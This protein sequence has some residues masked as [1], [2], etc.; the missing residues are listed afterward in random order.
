MQVC[1]FYAD[2]RALCLLTLVAR[3][4][5]A[6]LSLTHMFDLVVAPT[7]GSG[8]FSPVAPAAVHVLLLVAVCLGSAAC[9][10][11]EKPSSAA[12]SAPKNDI[13]FIKGF[14]DEE[15]SPNLT[16]RWMEN[17]GVIRLANT[18]R[19]MVLRLQGSALEHLD[20]TPTVTIELNGQLLDR[21]TGSMD[22]ETE[23]EVGAAMQSS[24]DASEL[25]IR[26][27]QVVVPSA[28]GISGDS[29]HLGLSMTEVSWQP[30]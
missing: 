2:F 23:Y 7:G 9:G 17:E 22:F 3:C 1:R 20:R 30:R 25:V 10:R 19:D 16:W 18:H 11:S 29:R 15:R 4:L 14:Y 5:L 26:T 27:D 13:A 28:I 8:R 12:A 6:S 21:I 24:G